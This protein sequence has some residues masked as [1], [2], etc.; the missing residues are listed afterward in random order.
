ML[1]DCYVEVDPCCCFVCS[2]EIADAALEAMQRKY[3]TLSQACTK[4]DTLVQTAERRE[5]LL[6]HNALVMMSEAVV[7][8]AYSATPR[9]GHLHL[10][11]R[12]HVASPPS[13]T[14]R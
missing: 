13:T 4:L 3:E 10:T 2:G 7:E 1:L 8:A 12:C 11:H 14:S 6:L 9:V 5:A